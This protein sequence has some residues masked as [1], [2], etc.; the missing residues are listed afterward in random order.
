MK[1]DDYLKML[2]LSKEEFK[3]Q[4]LKTSSMK[5]IRDGLI[6]SKLVDELDIKVSE[7]DVEKEF[8]NIAEKN[9]TNIEEVKKQV[10]NVSLENNIVYQKLIEK[11]SK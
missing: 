1:M 10:N 4:N 9:N 2:K 3:E 5:R 7:E 8:K 11:I 6:Y